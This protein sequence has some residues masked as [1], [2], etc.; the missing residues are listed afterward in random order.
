MPDP[1]LVDPRLFTVFSFLNHQGFDDE[2]REEG[3]HP[4]RIAI[5]EDL[6]NIPEDLSQEMGQIF[7]HRPDA[8]W[9]SVK[10][11]SF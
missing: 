10:R 4:V 5:R 7:Q 9:E 8:N 6:R 11:D 3:M 1:V 2:H